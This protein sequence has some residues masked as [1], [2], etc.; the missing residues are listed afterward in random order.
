MNHST[1]PSKRDVKLFRRYVR[2]GTYHI[3]VRNIQRFHT[4]GWLDYGP[5][6][7]GMEY[8]QTGPEIITPQGEEVL[9]P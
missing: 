7:H 8:F 5:D 9:R 6:V 2:G 3:K 4:L 1:V